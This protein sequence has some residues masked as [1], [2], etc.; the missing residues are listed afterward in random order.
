LA[1][2]IDWTLLLT[3]WVHYYWLTVTVLYY[4]NW[5]TLYIWTVRISNDN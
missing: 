3:N 2:D 1:S 5:C 4:T